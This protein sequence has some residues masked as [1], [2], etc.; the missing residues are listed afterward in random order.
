MYGSSANIYKCGDYITKVYNKTLRWMHEEH[1]DSVA[2]F[3]KEVLFLQ[4]LNRIINVT[5]NSFSIKYLG[6]SLYNNFYLPSDWREQIQNIF[7]ELTSCNIEYPEFNIKNIVVLDDNISFIDFGLAKVGSNNEDNCK[8]FIKLL[9][10]LNNFKGE[11]YIYS[12]FINN[13]KISGEYPN[14]IYI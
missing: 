14:N 3:N 9:E 5:E 7:K 1:D 2:I 13:L 6:E 11:K 12:T 8:V 10:L 4:K